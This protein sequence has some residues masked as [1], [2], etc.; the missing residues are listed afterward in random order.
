MTACCSRADPEFLRFGCCSKCTSAD[1]ACNLA[2]SCLTVAVHAL[3]AVLRVADRLAFWH[4]SVCRHADS[5]FIRPS[6]Y[7]CVAYAGPVWKTVYCAHNAE[8]CRIRTVH[9]N[10]VFA[11]LGMLIHSF[12]ALQCVVSAECCDLHIVN[13]SVAYVVKFIVCWPVAVTCRH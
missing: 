5:E 11:D 8:L 10:V 3:A 13:A 4:M 2:V 9:A 12:A 7:Y 1:C 6:E